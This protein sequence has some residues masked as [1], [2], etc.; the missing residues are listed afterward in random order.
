MK[1]RIQFQMAS[2]S[3]RSTRQAVG[4]HNIRPKASR[5]EAR[6]NFL[7]HRVVSDWNKIRREVNSTQCGFLKE[8]LCY[9]GV[10]GWSNPSRRRASGED[11]TTTQIMSG[12]IEA[13]ESQQSSK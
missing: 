2:D 10:N 3:T 4:P 9:G 12:P 7:S 5:P 13:M 6:R 11:M 1:S 8:K